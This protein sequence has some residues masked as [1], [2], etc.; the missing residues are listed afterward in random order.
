[1]VR[2]MSEQNS[3]TI[4]HDARLRLHE[5]REKRGYKLSFRISY[6]H[7]Y[8]YC[9]KCRKFYRT[10]LVRCPFHKITLRYKPRH[11]TPK[12]L[13]RKYIPVPEEIIREV[14]EEMY[15]RK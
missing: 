7:G 9:V 4:I 3:T 5:I 6:L 14:E 11:K 10:D 2:E 8:K 1:M 12:Y 13:R 15:M